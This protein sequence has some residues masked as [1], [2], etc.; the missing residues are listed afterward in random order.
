MYTATEMTK[1][2]F[3]ALGCLLVLVSFLLIDESYKKEV[4]TTITSDCTAYVDMVA[5]TSLDTLYIHMSGAN[6]E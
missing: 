3:Q 2:S 5:N 1:V 4:S 6:C